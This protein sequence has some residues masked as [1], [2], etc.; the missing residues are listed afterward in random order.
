MIITMNGEWKNGRPRNHVA[1]TIALS[2]VKL[3]KK[4]QHL[5]LRVGFIK[6]AMP[7]TSLPNGMVESQYPTQWVH[8]EVSATTSIKYIFP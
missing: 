4:M 3:P 1:Y 6:K 5:M 2:A 7:I 8:S